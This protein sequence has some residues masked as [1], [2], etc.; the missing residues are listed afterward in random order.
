MVDGK[1]VGRHYLG[2][3]WDIG[4]GEVVKGKVSAVAPG[5]A[6]GDIA[7]LKL[8]IVDRQGLID[9]LEQLELVPSQVHAREQLGLSE[10]VIGGKIALLGSGLDQRLMASTPNPVSTS[11]PV[12]WQAA[13]FLRSLGRQWAF[14]ASGS[15][16][17]LPSHTLGTLCH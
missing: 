11:Q 6:P 13:P 15:V 2:P 10:Q 3:S 14:P 17:P 16:R 12:F 1:T 7:L 5:A 4:N 8:D 9:L